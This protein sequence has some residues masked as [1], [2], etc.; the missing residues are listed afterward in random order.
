[1][2]VLDDLLNALMDLQERFKG[3]QDKDAKTILDELDGL[4]DSYSY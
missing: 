2:D 3:V 1:M 4:I